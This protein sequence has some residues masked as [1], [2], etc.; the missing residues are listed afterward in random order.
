MNLVKME[1]SGQIISVTFF[2]DATGGEKVLDA[3]H[4]H[5]LILSTKALAYC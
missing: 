5:C 3:G 4:P 1:I 2:V